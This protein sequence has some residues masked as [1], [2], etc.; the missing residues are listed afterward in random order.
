MLT[1]KA[2]LNEL[3]DEL[4]VLKLPKMAAALDKLY[5]R[6]EFLETDRMTLLA[7]IIGPE[8]Q[9]KVSKTLKNR[10]TAAKLKG[11]P[12]ELSKCVDSDQRSYE[13]NGITDVISSLDFIEHGYN[14]CILGASDAGKSYLARALGIQACNSYNVAYFHCEEFLESMVALKEKDYDKF[15]KKIQKYLRFEL[16]I[17]DDF[18]LHTITDEREIKI[19]FELLEKRNEQRKST[20]VCSQR[21]PGHWKAMILNDEVSANSIMKRATKHYTIK[22]NRKENQ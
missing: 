1:G 22:I 12:E 10:L 8:Y 3:V 17:L 20:I 16:I 21:D 7:D 14:L 2:L 19:L 5:N 18:L 9:E 11:S 13:P 4:N 6:P 15:A